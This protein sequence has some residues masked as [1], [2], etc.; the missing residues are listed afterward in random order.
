MEST[1]SEMGY[2]RG[3]NVT[4]LKCDSTDDAEAL[5]EEKSEMGQSLKNTLKTIP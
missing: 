1:L 4:F 3:E 2:P 5:Y